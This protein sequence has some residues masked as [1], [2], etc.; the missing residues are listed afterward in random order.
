MQEKIKVLYKKLEEIEMWF[1]N[2]Y[3]AMIILTKSCHKNYY[4]NKNISSKNK[5]RYFP[6]GNNNKSSINQ[7]MIWIKKLKSI[8]PKLGKLMLNI[9]LL[10]IK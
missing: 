7:L 10:G 4:L 3:K 2:N 1:K 5:I 8:W 9:S 6:R